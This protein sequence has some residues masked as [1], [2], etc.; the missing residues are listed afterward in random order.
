MTVIA[1]TQLGR[2]FRTERRSW[3]TV[4]GVDYVPLTDEQLLARVADER[5]GDAFDELYRRYSRAVYSLVLR[6]VRDA[7]LGEDVVQETFAA[8][9]RAARSYRQERGSATAWL[10]TIARNAAVDAVRSRRTTVAGDPPDVPDNAPTPEEQTV[11]E[12]EAFRVHVAVDELPD[13]EREVIELAYFHGLSQ[14]QVAQRLELPL[15]TVKTRTRAG[16]A[17]LAERLQHERVMS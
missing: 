6:V 4:A 8:V 14:S 17:R 2:S 3:T 11:A 10:F 1:S 5:D 12:L 7:A 15:G 9:W 13:R 16:L